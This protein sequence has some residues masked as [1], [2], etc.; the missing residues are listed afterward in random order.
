MPIPN[1]RF[2]RRY[3]PE[4]AAA[5][6]NPGPRRRAE[7]PR[8]AAARWGDTRGHLGSGPRKLRKRKPKKATVTR[9]Q[10]R[11]GTVSA[12]TLER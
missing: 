12:L 3:L 4:V 9:G 6:A 11:Q 10:E 2:L 1:A 5:V 8:K 7:H